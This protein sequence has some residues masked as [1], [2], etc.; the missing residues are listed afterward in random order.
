MFQQAQGRI[1]E[2]SWPGLLF[3]AGCVVQDAIGSEGRCQHTRIRS[4]GPKHQGSFASGAMKNLVGE[5]IIALHLWV[6]EGSSEDHRW[7]GS[8]SIL[9]VVPSRWAN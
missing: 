3:R 9:G 1:L 7:I 4:T 5:R 8:R 2:P 6:F